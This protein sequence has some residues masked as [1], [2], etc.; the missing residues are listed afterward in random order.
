MLAAAGIVSGG[1]MDICISTL[2]LVLIPVS[3]ILS[4]VAFIIALRTEK[5]LKEFL[6]QKAKSPPRDFSPALPVRPHEP[7]AAPPRAEAPPAP[8]A[9]PPRP[10]LMAAPA[11]SAPTV[12]AAPPVEEHARPAAAL[13]EPPRVPRAPAPPAPARKPIRWEEIIGLKGLAWVGIIAVLFSVAYFVLYAYEQGWFGHHPWVR[14]AIPGLLGLAVLVAGEYFSRK[15]YRPLARIATGGGLAALYFS[16]FAGW[17]LGKAPVI[18]GTATWPLMTVVTVV[19]IVLSVRYSSLTIAIFSLV[20]GLAAPVL[21]RSGEDPGHV[22]FLYVIAVNVGVLGVAYF[23]K[24]RVLN[25]MALAGTI[26]D[27]TIWLATFYWT[28]PTASAKLGMVVSYLSALWFLFFAL[29]VV[30]HLLGRHESSR[31]DLPVSILNVA[32]FYGILYNLLWAEHHAWLGP[33]AAALAAVYFAQALAMRR[34][35]AGQGRLILLQTGQAIALATL[36]IPI[37]LDGIYIPMAWA[38]WAAL[39]F[40]LGIRFDDWRLRVVGLG[41]H[42]VSLGA[43]G[44]FAGEAWQATGP[45]IFNGRVATFVLVGAALGFSAIRYGR[46]P[47]QDPTENTI[48]T[49]ATGV[50]H[51]VLMTVFVLEVQKWYDTAVA[52]LGLGPYADAG[53][54]LRSARDAALV[55]GFGVYGLLA[56]GLV[57]VLRRA[58]HHAMALLAIAAAF[59]LLAYAFFTGRL[60]HLESLPG[61]N[62]VGATFGALA[63]CLALAAIVSRYATGQAQW[64]RAFMVVY[65]LLA[66]AVAQGLFD[67]EVFRLADRAEHQNDPFCATTVLALCASGLAVMSALLVALAARIRSEAHRTASVLCIGGALVLLFVASVRITYAYDYVIVHPRGI[68]FLLAAA[69][70]AVSAA[71]ARYSAGAAKWRESFVWYELVAWACV[72]GLFLTEMVQVYENRGAGPDPMPMTTLLAC[73]A[74]GFAAYFVGLVGRAAWLRSLPHLVSGEVGLGAGLVLL[75]IACIFLPHAYAG[76]ILHARG[77]G[78]LILAASLA[79]GAAIVHYLPGAAAW[80]T[81]SVPYELLTWAAVLGLY[82]TETWQLASNATTAGEPWAEGS[83]LHLLAAG[84][85]V[86][87]GALTWRGL[88]I[89]SAAFR[90]AGLAC[91][92]GAVLLL[93]MAALPSPHAYDTVLVQP[94]GAAYIVLI[95]AVAWAVSAYAK[96]RPAGAAQ[97]PSP[98]AVLAVLLHLAVLVLFTFEAHDFWLARADRWFDNPEHGWYARHAT[99]SVGYALYAI[100]LLAAGIVRGRALLRVLALL[101]LAITILKVFL[102]DLREIQAIWR[103]ASFFGLGLL[104]MLGSLLYHKYRQVLFPEKAAE[105]T[106]EKS[107]P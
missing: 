66:L 12:S 60:P 57:A 96:P 31:L 105:K 29:M 22:L 14:V 68:A 34:W 77:A 81:R 94:R 33:V 99:L 46:C 85:A 21:I 89:G 98:A 67:V 59:G 58:V 47:K 20:G 74:A 88:R 16:V 90:T 3:L 23:K 61:L 56:V 40:W 84:V 104:L 38:V 64:N 80:R 72:L 9:P 36:A 93:A 18:P 86:Y 37:A 50:A 79:G 70:L 65:Q 52:A 39:L 24:W 73:C 71:V 107:E 55:V 17:A 63:G 76:P 15:G 48:M 69:S 106:P 35:A 1:T 13:D 25:V 83:L 6:R 102:F 92:A 26:I 49:I 54:P 32:W 42:L 97:E 45:L 5:L 30:Y 7:H 95:A 28:A 82:A 75:A 91:L 4:I 11:P 10:P 43:L 44:W 103:V 41:V 27:V 100:G 51:L 78:L 2:V 62:S 53:R 19:A 8:A 87:V 101:L